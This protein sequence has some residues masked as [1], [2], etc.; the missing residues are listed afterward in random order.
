[1]STYLLWALGAFA[2][3]ESLA[4]GGRTPGAPEVAVCILWPVAVPVGLLMALL[5]L[6]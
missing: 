6:E 2:V 5:G 1:M 3:A 4:K